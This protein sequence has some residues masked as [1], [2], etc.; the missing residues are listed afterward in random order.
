MP[1]PPAVNQHTVRPAALTGSPSRAEKL[2]RPVA[3]A[4]A[5]NPLD[6]LAGFRLSLR[7]WD[8]AL[9]ARRAGKG[10]PDD[11]LAVRPMGSRQAAFMLQ[12][13]A[14]VSFLLPTDTVIKV[15][16]AQGYVAS[17]IAMCLFMAWV[18]TAGFGFHNPIHNRHPVRGALGLLWIAS[19]LSYAAMPFYLPNDTQR[20]GADRFMMLLIGVSG[21]VLVAAEHLRAPL[22]IL[23][24]VRALVWGAAFSG[25]AA[26]LQFFL[27]WDVKPYLR[28]LLPGFDSGFAYDGLQTRDAL[29]RVSGTSNHP[30]ELGVIA[31]M[32]L[33]LAIWLAWEDKEKSKLRRWAPVLL[34]AVCIPMSISRSAVLATGVSLVVFVVLLPPVRRVWILAT[35]PVGLVAVFMLIPGYLRTISSYFGAGSSD[36]SITNRLDN[37]PRVI[38]AVKQAPWFGRGGGTFI[39]ADATRILDNQYLKSVMELGILGVFALCLYFF[40]PALAALNL[41]SRVQDPQLRAMC[42]ALAG[43][44]LAA[45]LGSFT[46]D[47]F[48][49]AQFVCVHALLMGLCGACWLYARRLPVPSRSGATPT[50]PTRWPTPTTFSSRPMPQEASS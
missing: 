31:G 25:L 49:F 47:S 15:I 17:L 24:V 35:V 28:L 27:R 6:R 18:W 16:G 9:H 32:L 23:R 10:R 22:D 11:Y 44:C 46:F 40:V 45:A 48:S 13:F 29:V 5:A 41:W 2:A 33:P 30:I 21:V 43:G 50:S 14:A 37:Y 8:E 19:L 1:D 7:R 4:R 26:I 12:L 34:I 20:L 38:A 3:L 42:A 39:A 36:P